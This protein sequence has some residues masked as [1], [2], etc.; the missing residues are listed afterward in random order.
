MLDTNQSSPSAVL[1][2]HLDRVEG[3]TGQ[4]DRGAGGGQGGQGLGA[5]GTAG[6]GRSFCGI[7][8]RFLGTLVARSGGLQV[9][10]GSLVA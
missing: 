3:A 4:E 8:A 10:S 2:P 6:R 5:P 9:F 1:Q 7:P